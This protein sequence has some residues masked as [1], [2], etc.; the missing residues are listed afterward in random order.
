[1]NKERIFMCYWKKL[2]NKK[3]KSEIYTCESIEKLFEYFMSENL[4]YFAFQDITDKAIED[5]EK[6]IN[7]IGKYT[8]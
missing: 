1:M 8:L 2:G 7:Y 6:E 3:I 5:F 4:V